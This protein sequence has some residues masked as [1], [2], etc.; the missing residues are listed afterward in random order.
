MVIADRSDHGSTWNPNVIGPLDR[1]LRCWTPLH[2]KR[3][4]CTTCGKTTL[5]FDMSL[6]QPRRRQCFQHT[7]VPAI[8]YC[9]LCARP[10]C[11]QCKGLETFPFPSP[12]VNWHCKKC[13]GRA[14]ELEHRFHELL[15]KR[16]C[17]AV[18]RDMN[19]SFECKKCSAPLC[20]SCSYFTVRGVFTQR[21]ADGPYCLGCFRQATFGSKNRRWI[22]GH[23]LSPGLV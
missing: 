13:L 14:A 16:R 18:H 3:G 8:R 2:A 1:C 19:R 21:V 6:R 7:G 10:I 12:G 5:I 22:S 11:E 17:C 15:E 23:D 4:Y 9:C 20:L